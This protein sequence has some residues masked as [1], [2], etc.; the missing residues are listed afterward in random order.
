[1]NRRGVKKRNVA[2]LPGDQQRDLSA[3][4]DDTLGPFCGQVANDPPIRV[5][6]RR[7]DD[8]ARQL[9]HDDPMHQRARFTVRHQSRDAVFFPQ[10]VAEEILLHGETN[11]SATRWC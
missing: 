8:A 10:P 6:G 4:Q 5:P 1:M 2:L 9:F 11:S 7:V 3:A